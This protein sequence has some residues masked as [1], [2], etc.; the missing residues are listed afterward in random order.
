MEY[1]E[2]TYFL[3]I[4]LIVWPFL[5]CERDFRGRGDLGPEKRIQLEK[6][7]ER[8]TKRK[9]IDDESDES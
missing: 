6:D 9:E 2:G 8:N 7:L 3:T 5:H 4:P 1:V